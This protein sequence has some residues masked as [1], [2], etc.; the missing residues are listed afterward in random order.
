MRQ[1]RYRRHSV[2]ET[3]RA[4]ERVA[5]LVD[6]VDPFD[7]STLEAGMR[8]LASDLDWRAGDLF[9]PVRIAVTGR[10]A[11]PPLFATMAV[12]GRQ[13]CRV[14]LQRALA[15]LAKLAAA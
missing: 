9:M 6:D 3:A 13:R 11:T 8:A 14:R 5:A 2:A 1:V 4:L 7:D 12:L 15:G 10:R